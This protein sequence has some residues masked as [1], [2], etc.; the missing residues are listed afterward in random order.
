MTNRSD[1]TMHGGAQR[2]Y[3]QTDKTLKKKKKNHGRAS[4]WNKP[5]GVHLHKL[6]FSFFSLS[7]ICHSDGYESDRGR[8]LS[9]GPQWE[10]Q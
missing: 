7:R 8:Q 6:G 4:R 10:V 9:G 5:S 3:A 1:S 2:L